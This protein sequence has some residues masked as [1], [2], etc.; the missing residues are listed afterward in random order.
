MRF[1]LSLSKLFTLIFPHSWGCRMH[2]GVLLKPD[3]RGQELHP[4]LF[5]T[6]SLLPTSFKKGFA[7]ELATSVAVDC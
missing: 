2:V 3:L 4:S 6:Y 1:A 5:A 7:E